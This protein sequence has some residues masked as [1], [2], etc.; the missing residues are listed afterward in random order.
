MQLSSQSSFRIFPLPQVE[1]SHLIPVNPHS[2]LQSHGTPNLLFV[3]TDLP[4][5]DISYIGPCA[6]LLSPIW[7][8]LTPWTVPT[9]LLCPWEFSTKNTEVGAIFSSRGS[10]RPRNWTWVSCISCI[11]GEFFTTEPPGKPIMDYI[12]YD[13]LCLT[14]FTKREYFEC[15]CIILSVFCSFLWLSYT[16]SYGW[17]TLCWSI[18]QLMDI[19]VVSTLEL[20][21]KLLLYVCTD[22]S[23]WTH[24]FISLG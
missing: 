4:L 23:L 5:M 14:S 9:R 8:F 19:W 22:K 16:L 12:I 10:S 2:C 1:A 18:H 3:S 13:I 24:L 15:H 11:A 6:W 20:L 17:T 21:W 7:L